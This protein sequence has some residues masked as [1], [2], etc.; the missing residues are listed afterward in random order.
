MIIQLYK[1]GEWK[2]DN[3]VEFETVKVSDVIKFFESEEFKKWLEVNGDK[4]T[5]LNP[6]LTNQQAYGIFY[7]AAKTT[8]KEFEGKLPFKNF[9]KLWGK[10]IEF[11]EVDEVG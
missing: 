7:G 5:K 2:R 3:W 4:F 8:E 1:Q 11:K 6:S 10:L 9:K